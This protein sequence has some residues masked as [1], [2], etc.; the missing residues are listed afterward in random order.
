MNSNERIQFHNIQ[1]ISDNVLK[2]SFSTNNG[3]DI[4]NV[5]FEGNYNFTNLQ[6][7]EKYCGPCI[8]LAVEVV[9]SVIVDIA[10]SSDDNGDIDMTEVC[11]AQIEA[12][13]ASGGTPT[14]MQTSTS[15][16][17]GTSCSLDCI[18]N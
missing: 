14:N 9:I 16:W 17:G 6:G 1:V 15:W 18:P 8:T 11:L 2:F 7:H 10:T 13:I 12:C 3:I 4:N 5:T